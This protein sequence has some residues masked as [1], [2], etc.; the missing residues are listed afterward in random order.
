MRE[1]EE[2]IRILKIQKGAISFKL[3][4][5]EREKAKL[6]KENESNK[7][8]KEKLEEFRNS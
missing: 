4:R 1:K 6:Q 5:S 7:A 8:E 2:K 3:E